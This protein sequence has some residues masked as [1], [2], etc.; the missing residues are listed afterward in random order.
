[1]GTMLTTHHHAR[2]RGFTLL[3]AVVAT[4]VLAVLAA[5][6]LPA[7]GDALHR[8]RRTDAAVALYAVLAAQERWRAERPAYAASVGEL[9]LPVQTP[10]GHYRIDLRPADGMTPALGFV[11]V[12]TAPVDSPQHRDP[13]CRTIA[14]RVDPAGVRVGGCS[15]CAVP[16]FGAAHPCWGLQ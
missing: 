8:A 15:G 9:G 11:A 16:A 6:A 12:A 10:S 7:F 4:A 2:R 14:L 5:L 1:M 3:E 13:A